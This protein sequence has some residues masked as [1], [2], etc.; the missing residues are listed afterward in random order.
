MEDT[1]GAILLNLEGLKVQLATMEDRIKG[2]QDDVRQMEA[3]QHQGLLR[4]D[5]MEDD[6]RSFTRP[7]LDPLTSRPSR[8]ALAHDYTING[9]RDMYP[10]PICRPICSR[11]WL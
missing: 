3:K 11:P 1:L 5:I 7:R 2:V 6:L 10:Q 4:V 9:Y 8:F